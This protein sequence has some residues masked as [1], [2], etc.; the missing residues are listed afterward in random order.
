MSVEL[1]HR[2]EEL[3]ANAWPAE[4]VQPLDGWRLRFTQGVSRR[5][6]SVWPNQNDDHYP[7]AEKV[8][9]VEEFYSRYHLPARYQICP[10]AQPAELDAILAGHGY[11]VDASTRVQTAEVTTILERASNNTGATITLAAT[12]TPPWL[13]AQRQLARLDERTATVRQGIL[14][15]IGGDSRAVPVFALAEQEGELTGTGLGVYEDGRL[16]VFNMITD[17]RYRRQG[18]A[19]AVVHRLAQWGQGQGAKQVYLQVMENNAPAKDLY[20]GLGF[21]TLYRYH[22]RESSR[23]SEKRRE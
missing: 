22:Y 11:T 4:V 16:G 2:L 3:A 19:T 17:S 8:A 23:L 5:A 10:A 21:T 1:V 6:N 18:V 15:R 13:D 14:E 9:L 12:L 7:L 20:Q